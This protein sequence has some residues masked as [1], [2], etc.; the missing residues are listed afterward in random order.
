[1]I[2]IAKSGSSHLIV[3]SLLSLSYLYNSTFASHACTSEIFILASFCFGIFELLRRLRSPTPPD[4]FLWAKVDY[5]LSVLSWNAL[6]SLIPLSYQAVLP[7]GSAGLPLTFLQELIPVP[8]GFQFFFPPFCS[9]VVSCSC[10][11]A[12]FQSWCPTL[13][14]SLYMT[15]WVSCRGRPRLFL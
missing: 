15:L 3:L 4:F 8:S 14:T 1:M 12:F 10:I 7:S 5:L 9:S 6:E 11:S 2:Q 13:H